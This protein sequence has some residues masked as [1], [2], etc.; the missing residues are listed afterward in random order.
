MF[1]APV[2]LREDSGAWADTDTWVATNYPDSR[3]S[4]KELKSG[5]CDGGTA[6]ARSYLKFDV[7]EFGGQKI[8][9]ANLSL[10]SY[11]S[12]SC[13]LHYLKGLP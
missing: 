8:F 1:A 3:S 13:A 7:A 2:R 5:T 6:K 4:S 10:Y 9:S 12:A 11:W